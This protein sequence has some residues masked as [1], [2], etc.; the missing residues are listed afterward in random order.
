MPMSS[1]EKSIYHDWQQKILAASVLRRLRVVVMH[2]HSKHEHRKTAMVT[3]SS[4]DQNF[5]SPVVA[6][7][8]C[9]S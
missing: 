9:I 4:T 1:N 8:V 7:A 2:F 6:L 5:T 3:G